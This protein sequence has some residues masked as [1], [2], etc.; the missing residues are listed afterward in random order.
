MMSEAL[1][2]PKILC[3]S[4]RVGSRRVWWLLDAIRSKVSFGLAKFMVRA[5]HGVYFYQFMCFDNYKQF[6]F[7]FLQTTLTSFIYNQMPF[8]KKIPQ[9]TLIL[10]FLLYSSLYLFFSKKSLL[11]LMFAHQSLKYFLGDIKQVKQL[12]KKNHDFNFFLLT[13][14]AIN[15]CWYKKKLK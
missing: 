12:R 13:I 11:P 3:P 14:L 9:I 4:D 6:L 1:K 8:K 5:S 2:K 15:I 10:F 7:S